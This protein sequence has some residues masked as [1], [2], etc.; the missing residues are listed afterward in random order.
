VWAGLVKLRQPGTAGAF[1]ASLGLPAPRLLVR[2]GALLEIAAGGAAAFWPQI[3]A[4]AIALLYAAFAALVTVQL[5][6]QTGVPC[7][8]L[9]AA[10]GPAS[11]VHLALNLVCTTLAASAAI[12]P[13]PALPTVAAADPLAAVAAGFVALA[14]ALLAVAAVDL[15]PATLGAWRGAEA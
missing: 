6:R 8:C 9:G 5:R 2:A 3:A 12:A 13:P 7:G 1:L 4:L 15:L 10:T 14:A 11:R